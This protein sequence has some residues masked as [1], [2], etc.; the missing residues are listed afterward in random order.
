VTSRSTA[1]TASVS[2]SAVGMEAGSSL[3]RVSSARR[4]VTMGM[5]GV[6]RRSISVQV[7]FQMVSGF[8]LART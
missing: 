3:R 1:L 5:A 6:K 7:K 2:S 4:A 8:V